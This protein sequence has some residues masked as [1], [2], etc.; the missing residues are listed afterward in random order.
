MSTHESEVP[1]TGI[2]L[3][4]SVPIMKRFDRDMIAIYC[5]EPCQ[6]N[7][8]LLSALSLWKDEVQ[9]VVLQHH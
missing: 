3:S 9:P 8:R 2:L 6:K 1:T 4:G 5:Q 7:G